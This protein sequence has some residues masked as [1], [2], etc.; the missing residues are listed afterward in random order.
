MKK[1]IQEI[2]I[3]ARNVCMQEC[4]INT[5]LELNLYNHIEF[6]EEVEMYVNENDIKGVEIASTSNLFRID[7]NGEII[8]DEFDETLVLHHNKNELP[9]GWTIDL[10]NEIGPSHSW[11]CYNGIYYDAE[12]IEGVNKLFDLPYYKKLIKEYNQI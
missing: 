12:C 10:V 2:L 5:Y 6:T 3:E 8:E 11:I 9:N 1:T 4:N 7:S